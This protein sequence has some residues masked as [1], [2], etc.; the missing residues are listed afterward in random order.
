MKK[1]KTIYSAIF[2]DDN[3]KNNIKSLAEQIFKS[4]YENVK[5]HHITLFFGEREFEYNKQVNFNIVGYSKDEFCQTFVVDLID[6]IS[7][8]EENKKLHITVSHTSNVTPSYSNE[9]LEK[10]KIFMFD[11]PIKFSGK[12]GKYTRQGIFYE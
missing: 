8:I 3:T 2:F 11:K 7:G 9:L 6:N 1:I 5:I 4:F 10:S 12:V